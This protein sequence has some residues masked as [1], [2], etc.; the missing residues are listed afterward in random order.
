MAKPRYFT[1]V[2]EVEDINNP[3][4]KRTVL[5]LGE[6]KVEDGIDLRKF[7]KEG[8]LM[9][10]EFPIKKF[11]LN[12]AKTICHPDDKFDKEYGI[13]KCMKRIKRL[14]G[15]GKLE[16]EQYTMLTPDNCQMIVDHKADHIAAN[17]TRY[18][19]KKG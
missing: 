12:L 3:T 10:C 14:E 7:T 15:I 5:V 11:V 19:P 4:E 9:T 18:L 13:K 16:T 2:R 8:V 6:W 17:I 1:A